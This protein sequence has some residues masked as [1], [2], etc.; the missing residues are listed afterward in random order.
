L[1][2]ET[3]I[4]RESDNPAVGEIETMVRLLEERKNAIRA[5]E[6]EYNTLREQIK[7]R[8][9]EA[10][11][12]DQSLSTIYGMV[13]LVTSYEYEYRDSEVTRQEKAVSVADKALKAVKKLLKT[14]QELAILNKKAKVTNVTVSLRYY[15]PK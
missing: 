5:E 4:A 1:T 12:T 9:I 8:M 10:G 2:K 3:I 11:I 6:A 13:T 15:E 7:E 14:A